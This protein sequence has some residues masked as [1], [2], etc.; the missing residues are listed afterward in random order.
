M[1]G[2]RGVNLL[3]KLINEQ[4]LPGIM[5]WTPPGD[6]KQLAKESHSG[7]RRTLRRLSGGLQ[8]RN[9]EGFLNRSH[10]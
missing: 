10:C 9:G 2:A 7:F 8:I 5:S 3:W 4:N 6:W 1:M